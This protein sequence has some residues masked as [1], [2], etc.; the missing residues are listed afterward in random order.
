[1]C[2]PSQRQKPGFLSGHVLNTPAS[3][4][5]LNLPHDGA[6]HIH[7]DARCGQCR[8]TVK[9]GRRIEFDQIEP[10]DPGPS[11]EA[12]D[13]VD[14]LYIRQ[15]ARRTGRYAGHNGEIEAIAIKGDDNPRTL[16]NMS[17]SALDAMDVDL[18]CGYEAA[19]IALGRFNFSKARA[20][21][22]AKTNLHGAGHMLHFARPSHRAGIPKSRRPDAENEK[23]KRSRAER[24]EGCRRR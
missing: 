1:M 7:E 17:E 16:R 4:P 21:D 5:T 12:R 18:A 20:S 8:H 14:D 13:Q 15:A 23:A 11:A 24:Q 2:H 3:Q 19:A 9:V 10:Y 22:A 6:D